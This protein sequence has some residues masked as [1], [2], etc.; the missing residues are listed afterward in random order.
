MNHLLESS[1]LSNFLSFDLTLLATY[2][3][4]TIV[5]SDKELD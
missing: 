4:F 1:Y 5:Y 3:S 2:T